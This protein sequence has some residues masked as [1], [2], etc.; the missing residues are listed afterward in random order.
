MGGHMREVT[1]TP[2]T[3]SVAAQVS[4]EWE[5]ARRRA[6]PA[7]NTQRTLVRHLEEPIAASQ[8]TAIRARANALRKLVQTSPPQEASALQRR[9]NDRSDPLAHLFD[10]E[11]S[12]PLRAELRT[13]LARRPVE[14]ERGTFDRGTEDKSTERPP[15][16]P[17]DKPQPPVPP[18]VPQKPDPTKPDPKRPDPKRPDPTKTQTTDPPRIKPG[19]GGED[20]RRLLDWLEKIYGAAGRALGLGLIPLI[21]MVISGSSGKVALDA[22]IIQR[23]LQAAMNVLMENRTARQLVG[24]AGEAIAEEV[25]EWL[26]EKETGG[27]SRPFNLN[28]LRKNFPL[29]DLIDRSGIYGVKAR[30]ALTSGDVTDSLV[31]DLF[32]FWSN[33]GKEGIPKVRKAAEL[34]HELASVLQAQDHWPDDLA[35]NATS[36]VIETYIRQ[37]GILL[38]PSDKWYEVQSKVGT[39]VLSGLSDTLTDAD[40]V[41]QVTPYT[42]R[43]RSFGISSKAIGAM[44]K[45]ADKLTKLSAGG[46]PAH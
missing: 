24:D 19:D 46:P 16:P 27:R 9:L 11:L 7:D 17:P 13:R 44:L 12:T 10:L 45:I 38:V 31:G 29:I 8:T 25:Y 28:R 2:V 33:T 43:V 35:R 23:A 14:E 26:R 3:G 40:K 15:P 21:G 1:K 18:V 5:A 36:E 32:E 6:A 4:P 34:L 37:K 22:T 42:S 30:G 39:R 20:G 41:A